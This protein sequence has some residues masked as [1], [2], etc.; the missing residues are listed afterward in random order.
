MF[1]VL[2]RPF[3][4]TPSYTAE[5]EDDGRGTAPLQLPVSS[6]KNHDNFRLATFLFLNSK[7]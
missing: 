5:R 7:R 6:K 4:T 3:S 2:L 1:L